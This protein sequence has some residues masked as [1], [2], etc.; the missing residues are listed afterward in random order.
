MNSGI[1]KIIKNGVE[2]IRKISKSLNMYTLATIVCL[3]LAIGLFLQN[4]L[5]AGLGW[6]AAAVISCLSAYREISL[7]R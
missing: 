4:D 1:R 7:K 6:L 5:L 2:E 3:A